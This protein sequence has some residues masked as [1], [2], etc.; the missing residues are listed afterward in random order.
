MKRKKR[1]SDT[2]VITG[3][4]AKSRLLEKSSTSPKNT[5]LSTSASYDFGD[6]VTHQPLV[7][8]VSELEVSKESLFAFM[9]FILPYIIFSS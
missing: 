7:P 8:R 6:R 3:P 5:S 2:A 1:A 9:L 4:P